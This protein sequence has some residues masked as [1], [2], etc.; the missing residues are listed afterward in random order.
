MIKC[1]QCNN[2][3]HPTKGPSHCG[4]RYAVHY[5]KR[6]RDIPKHECDHFWAKWSGFQ[7]DKT[8]S[9]PAPQ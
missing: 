1:D 6:I 3:V 9:K 4:E 2:V 8:T 5:N 7:P